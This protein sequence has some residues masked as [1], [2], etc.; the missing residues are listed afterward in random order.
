MQG[1]AFHGPCP[2]IFLNVP[3]KTTSLPYPVSVRNLKGMYFYLDQIS[4][5][6]LTNPVVSVYAYICFLW[7]YSACPLV[8]AYL[9]WPAVFFAS[10][11]LFSCDSS[12][13]CPRVASIFALWNSG[14]REACQFG[15]GERVQHFSVYRSHRGRV[16]VPTPTPGS[17]Q[18]SAAPR[19]IY[20][21][22]Y[23]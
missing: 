8:T 21:H 16:G 14:K 4:A 15:A 17:S 11:S 20:L 23:P 5:G 3:S 19:P 22:T 7:P 18:P 12:V 2:P 10:V 1:L 9:A 13:I 6:C